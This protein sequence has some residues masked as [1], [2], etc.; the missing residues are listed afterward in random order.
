MG[1]FFSWMFGK[2]DRF[3]AMLRHQVDVACEA[4]ETLDRFIGDYDSITSAQR[5]ERVQVIKDLEHKGDRIVHAVINRL[6]SSFITPIDKEDL[7]TLATLL[8]DITDDITTFSTR[9]LILHVPKVDET[10]RKFSSVILSMAKEVRVCVYRLE[11]VRNIHNH[12]L[13]VHR[14]EHEADELFRE[15]LFRLFS[16]KG[17]PFHIIQYKEVYEHLEAIADT[18]DHT[19]RALE[20]V[21][22]KRD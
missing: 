5:A 18:C 13:T 21:S 3:F 9:L 22:M 4:A 16:K 2:Q 11:K 1:L 12:A 17:N 7:H 14:L 6:N 10:I 15:A 20:S 19:M 8:D